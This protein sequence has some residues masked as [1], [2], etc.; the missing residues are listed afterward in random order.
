MHVFSMSSITTPMEGLAG[1]VGRASNLIPFDDID[2]S[3]STNKK[4]PE[5]KVYQE[6]GSNP[7]GDAPIG[8]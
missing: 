8:T 2:F 5:K 1:R 6:W 7:R 4:K 3:P